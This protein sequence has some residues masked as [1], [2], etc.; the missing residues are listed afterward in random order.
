MFLSKTIVHRD[1]LKLRIPRGWVNDD[2]QD[3]VSIYPQKGEGA[4]T[5]SFLS[6]L[7]DF[8]GEVIPFLNKTVTDFAQQA[9]IKIGKAYILNTRDFNKFVIHAIGT[10]DDWLVKLWVVARSPRFLVASYF[11]KQKNMKEMN[12]AEA[13]INSITYIQ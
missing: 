13:I 6:S 11:T 12:A 10:Q 9:N 1:Y 2:S 4:I 8:G 3:E 7:S 5:I